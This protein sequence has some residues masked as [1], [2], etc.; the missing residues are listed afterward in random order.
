[1]RKISL[2]AA[3]V[4]MIFTV[5]AHA[6]GDPKVGEAKAEQCFDCHGVGGNSKDSTF[7]KLAGQFDYY[8]VKQ[9]KDF[10]SGTRKGHTFNDMAITIESDQDVEDIAAYFSTQP[11]MAG[12]PTDP[13]LMVERTVG[14]RRG[15]PGGVISVSM[16]KLGKDIY[17]DGGLTKC[18]ECHG[19]GARGGMMKEAPKLAGQHK[20]YLIKAMDDVYSRKRRADMFNLMWRG[21]STLDKEEWGFVAEYLSS[22]PAVE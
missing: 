4:I 5:S 22:I 21:V 8:I 13:P 16:F 2:F 17:M 6:A 7:P 18:F 10:K 20:D 19:E 11:D 3:C 14:D 1:M 15:E 9:I 12:E